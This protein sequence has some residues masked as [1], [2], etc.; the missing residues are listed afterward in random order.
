MLIR[1]NIIFTGKIDELLL[2]SD[3][4]HHPERMMFNELIQS[5]GTRSQISSPQNSGIKVSDVKIKMF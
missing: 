1:V 4:S 3:I 2:K 5:L